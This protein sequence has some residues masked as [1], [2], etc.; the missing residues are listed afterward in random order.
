MTKSYQA[1]E[2]S[3]VSILNYI[4]LIYAILFGWLLFDETFNLMTYA[5]MALVILGVILNVVFKKK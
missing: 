4:G 2:L 1:E 5:G 3:K